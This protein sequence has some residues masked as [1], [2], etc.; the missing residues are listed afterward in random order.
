MK[1]ILLSVLFLAPLFI[2]AQTFTNSAGG[3]ITDDDTLRFYPVTV[4]GLQTTID[5]SFG[6][7]QVVVN[8]NH[9]YDSDL[10]IKLI[11]P[12]GTIV[13]LA[14]NQGGGGDNY[15]NTVFTM[16]G[17][18][19][20]IGAGTAP[21]TG[22]YIPFNSINIENN[23]QNPNGTWYLGIIDEVP[24][25]FGNL[26]SFS[27]IFGANPPHD[28]LVF[29]PCAAANGAGC[30]CPDGSQDCDLLPDMTA[31]A[32]MIAGNHTET[33]G[34]MTLSNA[35]PNIGWGP[36]EIHGSNSCWC[37]TVNVAC[38]T[39]ICPDGSY[40]KQKLLQ[41]IYHKNGNV[42]T[43]RDTLT[44]GTMSYHPQ[45]N[46][47]HVNNWA[48]F[49]LRTPTANPDA[50]T[51]PIVATGSKISFCLINLGNCTSGYGVC[52]ENNGAGPIVTLADI[53]N[54]GFGQVTGCG[55]DQG[56]YVGDY[57]IY[58]QGLA[59]MS[60]DLTGVCNGNYY[61]VSITDPDN[62]FIES[63]E[64]NNWAATPVTLTQQ[65]P[66]PVASFTY[67]ANGNNVQF[68]NPANINN[69]YQWYF[70]D[71][72]S[73]NNENPSHVYTTNGTF[74][75]T[76]IVSSNC[77]ADTSTHYITLL[78]VGIDASPAA[79]LGYSIYPN[80]TTESTTVSYFV[81]EKSEVKF[82]L[83]NVMGEKV[84]SASKG[85]QEIG[86]YEFNLNVKE[87]GLSNGVYTLKLS[88]QNINASIRLVQ[89]EK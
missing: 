49:T 26:I 48:E 86:H 24:N 2:N 77:G 15:T 29:G 38:S 73:T 57:D 66:Q 69:T 68:F 67:T 60:M 19:G 11:S 16:N 63:N 75:V 46:H 55:V 17:S 34:L 84:Y 18:S 85:T 64:T 61:I 62:N 28:P 43:S 78:T 81:P 40:P 51:W 39:L 20:N 50:T 83:F 47:I 82:E 13:L 42:I 53:P 32:L 8:I 54:S 59:G 76:E 1:K 37:D 7:T 27:I 58:G 74:A 87:I 33:P 45:H 72:G 88:T 4:S 71:G 23:N 70:G 79:V 41:T 89:L 65:I 14:S 6:V 9:T 21:F 80:P 3:A 12:N 22:S 5:T 25:D 36:M 52:V 31:S 56:I 35:T 44:Q 10:K 30:S